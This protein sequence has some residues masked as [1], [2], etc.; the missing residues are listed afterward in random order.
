[1]LALGKC[2]QTAL[3]DELWWAE[4]DANGTGKS[5]REIAAEDLQGA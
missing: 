5:K 4:L 2:Q 3:A 1:M